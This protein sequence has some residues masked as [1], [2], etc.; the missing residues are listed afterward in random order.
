MS[1]ETVQISW[2]C[3]PEGSS[4]TSREENHK[5]PLEEDD[6]QLTLV[7]RDASNYSSLLALDFPQVF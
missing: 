1:T 7:V 4:N 6:R 3:N 2:T 5:D